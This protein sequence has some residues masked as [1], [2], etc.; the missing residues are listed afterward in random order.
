MQ[1]II[2]RK[3][4]KVIKVQFFKSLF[5]MCILTSKRV[6]HT[7]F[8]NKNYIFQLFLMFFLTFSNNRLL[9]RVKKCLKYLV[10]LA[11]WEVPGFGSGVIAWGWGHFLLFIGVIV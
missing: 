5:L 11:C 8:D 6:L 2:S 10:P 1:S 4:K 9:Y 7:P 3:K